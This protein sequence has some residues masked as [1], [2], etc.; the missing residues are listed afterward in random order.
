MN[1]MS[2]QLFTGPSLSCNQHRSIAGRKLRDLLDRLE[3]IGRD[4]LGP[5]PLNATLVERGFPASGR[6]NGDGNM[7][8]EDVVWMRKLGLFCNQ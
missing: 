2:K 3:E 8:G 4:F 6:S 5:E 7:R 1:G